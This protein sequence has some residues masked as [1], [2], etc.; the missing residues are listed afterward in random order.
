MPKKVVSDIELAQRVCLMMGIIQLSPALLM[1]LH[2]VG[3]ITLVWFLHHACLA[4]SHTLSGA[5]QDVKKC[6]N[7]LRTQSAG[8]DSRA[9]IN[10]SVAERRYDNRIAGNNAPVFIF[11]EYGFCQGRVMNRS[12]GGLCIAAESDVTVGQAIRIQWLLD[13]NSAVSIDM[14]VCHVRKEGNEWIFGC[15]F[16]QQQDPAVLTLFG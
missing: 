16:L 1:P 4:P 13:S 9:W 6:L 11:D 10:L 15:R 2:S 7:E 8:P 3:A 14:E 12:R 5:R